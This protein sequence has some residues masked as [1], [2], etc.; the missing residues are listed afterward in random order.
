MT[1]KKILLASAAAV[2]IAGGAYAATTNIDALATFVAAVTLGNEVDM[3][4]SSVAFSAAPTVAGDNV[5]LGTDGSIAYNGVFSVGISAT[6]AAGEVEITAGSVGAVVDIEC[7]TTATMGDGGGESINVINI[8]VATTPGAFGTGTACAGIGTPIA[9]G[10]Y[11]LLGG[12]ADVLYFGGQIDGASASGGFGAG[13][14]SS[15]TGGDDIQVDVNY[16]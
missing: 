4:F 5:Q 15:A 9:G 1:M 2:S 16:Q 7:D 3:D 12:G 6:P 11:T 14:Y 10:G 13:T 8:E